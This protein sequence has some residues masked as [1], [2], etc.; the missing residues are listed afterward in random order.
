[1]TLLTISRGSRVS[2]ASSENPPAGSCACRGLVRTTFSRDNLLLHLQTA[3]G[4]AGKDCLQLQ[5]PYIVPKASP[6]SAS[7]TAENCWMLCYSNR[8]S[9]HM[10]MDM[11]PSMRSRS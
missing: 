11:R 5:Q 7:T 3:V 2:L 6:G 4:L 8:L 9:S 1:M 10:R